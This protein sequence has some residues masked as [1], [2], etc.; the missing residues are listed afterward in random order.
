MPREI[1]MPDSK[2]IKI[3][4]NIELAIDDTEDGGES[5][6]KVDPGLEKI[7]SGKIRADAT[8]QEFDKWASERRTE[9]YAN[10]NEETVEGKKP[11]HIFIEPVAE[12]EYVPAPVSPT[13]HFATERKQSG[14]R[15]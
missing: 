1:L 14:R 6:D 12:T 4:D 8:D 13:P 10:I 11:D 9:V 2:L 15:T 3:A 7:M 5:E